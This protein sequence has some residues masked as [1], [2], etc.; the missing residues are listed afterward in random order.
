MTRP[1]SVRVVFTV[2][3]E[4]SVGDVEAVADLGVVEAAEEKIADDLHRA[5]EAYCVESWDSV[6]VTDYGGFAQA[7]CEC[8][9]CETWWVMEEDVAYVRK[10]GMCHACR[11]KEKIE[12]LRAVLRSLN[13]GP[14]L[15]GLPLGDAADLAILL[16]DEGKSLTL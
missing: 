10:H 4:V 2:S 7:P 6:Q 16:E 5:G 8:P 9:G 14:E 12:R 13:A 1:A 11:R 15:L 3:A